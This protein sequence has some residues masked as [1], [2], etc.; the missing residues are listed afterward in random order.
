MLRVSNVI[1]GNDMSVFDA[2]VMRLLLADAPRKVYPKNAMV[3]SVG[4]VCDGLYLIERGRVRIV[5]N[6]DEGREVILTTL[7]AGEYFGEM[8][9]IDNE[10]RSATVV[11]TEETGFRV[12]S[13]HAFEQALATRPDTAFQ[14]LVNLVKRLREADRKIESLALLDVYGRLART[15]L[16]LAAEKDGKLVVENKPTHQDLANMIGASRE[17]VTRLLGDLVRGNY[18]SVEH[19]RFILKEKLPRRW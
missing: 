10:E 3:F 14:L 8:A 2:D 12:I 19:N 13:R 17:M 1:L 11:T 16:E 18:I 7:A 4:D 6:D 5:I 15:L 9:L